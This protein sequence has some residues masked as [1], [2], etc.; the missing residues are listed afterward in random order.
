MARRVTYCSVHGCGS[1][2]H[3]RGLCVK[4]YRRLTKHADVETVARVYRGPTTCLITTCSATGTIRRGLCT[5]H[6][7]RWRRNGDPEARPGRAYASG[8]D[9]HAWVQEP[10]YRTVHNRLD[11]EHGPAASHA[12][13][14]CGEAAR[15][16]S[17]DHNDPAERIGTVSGGV[18]VPYSTKLEHYRPL[19]HPCHRRADLRPLKVVT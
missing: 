6:Y 1:R 3:G 8:S 7:E 19:C 13:A 2:C 5:M 16:W 14:I 9:H 18:V 17:Y 11:R 15:Q 10:A 4:H 12:C